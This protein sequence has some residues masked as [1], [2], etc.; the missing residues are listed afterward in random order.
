MIKT[1]NPKDISQ[2]E[3]HRYLLSAIAPRP[4]CFASTIDKAGHVNLSPFSFFNVFS[5]NP[6]IMVFSPSRRGRDNTTKH[7]YENVK[8]V[9]EVVI[10]IVNF[11]MVEQMSLTSTEYEKG[12][13]EFVKAGFTQVE[14]KKVKPPRVG[15]AP[16]SFECV[17]DQIIEL[18]D[19]PGAGNLIV[20]RV[21]LMHMNEAYLDAKEMLD[22]QKLDLVA[23]MGGSWY[24][25]ASRAALFEIPKP[26]RKK[27]IGV[28]QLPI[29]VQTSEVLTGNHL[30]RLANV[31]QLPNKDEVITILSKK[32]V[33]DLFERYAN[34]K[35]TM[36]LAIHELAKKWLEEGNTEGA[37][38]LLL[39]FSFC[40]G[41]NSAKP[42]TNN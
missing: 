22:T 33:A 16:V 8:E 11:A 32:E 39:V 12:V 1:I 19:G 7:T 3:L 34:D 41:I 35:H 13:N 20:A 10:N 29:H 25:R 28:D 30:G 17:V 5:S 24:A 4:I 37:L 2:T 15:E 21:V 23:R 9:K 38:K 18:V 6:P 26:L 42:T 14:S 36:L 27:G 40:R 31:E